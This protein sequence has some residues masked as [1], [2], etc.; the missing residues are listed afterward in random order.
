[1][2]AVCGV[3]KV[4][5]S[6]IVFIGSYLTGILRGSSPYAIASA[7]SSGAFISVSDFPSVIEIEAEGELVIFTYSLTLTFSSFNGFVA[8]RFI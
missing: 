8:F 3:P 4:C 5:C 2:L 1:M 7:K 6:F